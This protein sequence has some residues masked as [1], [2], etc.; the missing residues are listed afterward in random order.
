MNEWIKLPNWQIIKWRHHHGLASFGDL[1]R[2]TMTSLGDVI[3]SS[4]EVTLYFSVRGRTLTETA[5]NRRATLLAQA[6]RSGR[7]LKEHTL[8]R[9]FPSRR[10]PPTGEQAPMHGKVCTP[11][12]PLR[13]AC[14][15]H[16]L[17]FRFP[18]CEH[19]SDQAN[20]ARCNILLR[21]SNG[22]AS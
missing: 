3:D 5:N 18:P 21:N 1:W 16:A 19:F 9:L 10:A 4:E 12:Q 8:N 7:G 2:H 15:P 13:R 11:Q 6:N 17:T 20:W 14:E 22:K